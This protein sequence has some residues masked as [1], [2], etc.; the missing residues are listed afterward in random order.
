MTSKVI[1]NRLSFN[2]FQKKSK[3]G[4]LEKSRFFFAFRLG[5]V[6]EKIGPFST[7]LHI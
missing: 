5:G 4:E 1:L 6:M 3:G 7:F 2:G